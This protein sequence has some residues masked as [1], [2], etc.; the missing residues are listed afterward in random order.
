MLIVRVKDKEKNALYIKYKINI[1]ALCKI[2]VDFKIKK[3]KQIA[4]KNNNNNNNKK[5]KE[6]KF[7]NGTKLSS[8]F[9]S[10]KTKN[11]CLK[12]QQVGKI[13]GK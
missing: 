6:L 9:F 11:S 8:Y 13:V 7:Q 2:T 10:L 12:S 1:I 4:N 5:K 3:T